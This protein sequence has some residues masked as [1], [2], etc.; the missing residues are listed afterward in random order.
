MIRRLKKINPR[1]LM[2]HLIITLAYPIA[3]GIT[4]ERNG[5]TVFTDAMT[6]IALVLVIGGIA[7]SFV[8]KGDF[9]I[10]SFTFRKGLRKKDSD[11]DRTDFRKFESRRREDREKSFNYPLFLGILYLIAAAF[12]A[13]FVI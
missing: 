1:V 2:S 11:K 12:L 3:K 13:N 9:D 8:L 7:Y 10:S 6:I 4:A 5:L